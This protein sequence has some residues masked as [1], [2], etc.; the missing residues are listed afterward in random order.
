M[1]TVPAT[2]RHEITWGVKTALLLAFAPFICLF[3]SIAFHWPLPTFPF[4]NISGHDSPEYV[5][6]M[7][8]RTENLPGSI[9][10]AGTCFVL[11]WLVIVLLAQERGTFPGVLRDLGR[12]LQ[13]DLN[14][15]LTPE[16]WMHSYPKKT[17]SI[18]G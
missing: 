5:L 14:R 16:T 17:D 1:P 13:D 8:N 2:E 10:F 7:A 12:A 4:W 3:F 9:A 6:F 11:G 18:G 15:I